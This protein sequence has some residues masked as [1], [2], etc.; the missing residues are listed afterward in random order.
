MRAARDRAH[1][2]PQAQSET[3]RLVDKL[4]NSMKIP[5][6]HEDN[7]TSHWLAAAPVNLH[8]LTTRANN[9]SSNA[10]TKWSGTTDL[11]S[12][13]RVKVCKSRMDACRFE[14]AYERGEAKYALL[15][16]KR[17]N[18]IALQKFRDSIKQP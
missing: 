6:A 1:L 4:I 2:R 10:E 14:G 12:A 16:A 18:A 9:D 11:T 13:E 7:P 17:L 8:P 5:R 15:E 3:N